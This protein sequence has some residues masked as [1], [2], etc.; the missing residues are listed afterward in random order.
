[1]VVCRHC[2]SLARPLMIARGAEPFRSLVWEAFAYPFSRRGILVMVAAGIVFALLKA[3][4]GGW[5]ARLAFGAEWSLLFLVIRTSALG[6]HDVPDGD[7]VAHPAD[8]FATALKAVLASAMAL[9]PVAVYLYFKLSSARSVVD[10]LTGGHASTPVLRDPLFY[11]AVAVGVAWGPLSVML[12]AIHTPFSVILN[13][14]VFASI[15]RRLGLDYLVAALVFWGVYAASWYVDVAARAFVMAL[16]VP[17]LPRMVAETMMLYLP[18]VYARVLG[19]LLY[20]RGADLGY[21]QRQDYE[22][23]VLGGLEPAQEPV[24]PAS[25]PPPVEPISLSLEEAPSPTPPRLAALAQPSEA[26]ALAELPPL[27]LSPAPLPEPPAADLMEEDQFMRFVEEEQSR[28][29]ASTPP[30]PSPRMEPLEFDGGPDDHAASLSFLPIAA[31]PDPSP[32]APSEALTLPDLPPPPMLLAAPVVAAPPADVVAVP[33]PD[34]VL[35]AEAAPAPDQQ[36]VPAKDG[37]GDLEFIDDLAPAPK[38]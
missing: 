34:P 32:A 3:L 7:D 8:L 35:A 38:K 28:R 1:M 4:A 19:L 16:P 10:V 5:G 25:P 21:G 14:L 37:W 36:S 6:E 17:V 15:L 24:K 18:L 13:P 27:P 11:V 29:A 2:A 26:D 31:F 20:V 33:A 12:A 9:L 23:P 22:V 30:L